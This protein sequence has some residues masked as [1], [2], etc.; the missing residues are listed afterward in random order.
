MSMMNTLGRRIIAAPLRRGFVP[1]AATAG[2]LTLTKTSICEQSRIPSRFGTSIIRH[3]SALSGIDTNSSKEDC[4]LCKKFS[5][6]PCG[7]LF[8]TWLACTEQFSGK[9]PENNEDLHLSKCLHLAK[10]LGACLEQHEDHYSEMDIYAEDDEEEDD[11]MEAWNQVIREV[12][13]TRTAVSFETPP[14]LQIRLVNNT[15]M[16][17]FDYTISGNKVVM[18]YVR[19]ED[20]GELLAA[21]SIDDLWDYEGRGVL[22][23]SFGPTCK[24][25][26]VYALYSDEND[27]DVLYKHSQRIPR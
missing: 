22:R 17:S 5:Q 7:E 21:G 1:V 25:V 23:L 24:S 4:P 27:K 11:L 15:G 19:D 18:T 12:E 3:Q 8:K 26:A 13:A 6:G 16:A 9:D 10:P 14:D 20:T 2:C